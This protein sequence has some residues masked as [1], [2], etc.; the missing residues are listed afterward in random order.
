[1]KTKSSVLNLTLTDD[2]GFVNFPATLL[3]LENFPGWV[4]GLEVGWLVDF[5][6]DFGLGLRICQ[7]HVHYNEVRHLCI[8]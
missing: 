2:F 5:D 6:F 1:M 8:I 3:P 7:C 4:E